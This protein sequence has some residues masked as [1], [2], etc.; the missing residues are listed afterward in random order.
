[1]RSPSMEGEWNAFGRIRVCAPPQ[2]FRKLLVDVE[3]VVVEHY[4]ELLRRAR[5]NHSCR[6]RRVKAELFRA[7]PEKMG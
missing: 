7:G 3:R 6:A 4:F 1:M 2:T 5:R